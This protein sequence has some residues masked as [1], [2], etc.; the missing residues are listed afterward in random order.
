MG[1][2]VVVKKNGLL[3]GSLSQCLSD[4]ELVEAIL[5]FENAVNPF[6]EGI[7]VTIADLA[8]A[9]TDLVLGKLVTNGL[10]GVLA[11]MITVKDEGQVRGS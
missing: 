4:K 2:L 11:A 7:V 8:H 9:G 6:G 3:N 5:D 10:C 1:A